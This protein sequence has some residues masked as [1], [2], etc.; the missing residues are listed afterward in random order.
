[1]LRHPGRALSRAHAW[2][3]QPLPPPPETLRRGPLRDGTFRS[4]L[5]SARLTT[6]TGLALAAAFTVCLL[7]GVL[8]HLIQHPPGW[9]WWPSRPVGLYRVTQGLH[10]ATGLA[11]VPLLGVKLWSVY[12]RLFAWPRCATR[13]ARSGGWA[14]PCWSPVRCSRSRAAC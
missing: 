13:P 3:Q 5:R 7:T 1:M 2:L 12:P 9:F 10:V 6:L 14:S 4:P 8:S 11:S